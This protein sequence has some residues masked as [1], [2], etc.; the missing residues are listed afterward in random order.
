MVIR[1]PLLSNVIVI[2][3]DNGKI[4]KAQRKTQRQLA[5]QD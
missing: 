4:N 3:R 5:F 2:E 1:P